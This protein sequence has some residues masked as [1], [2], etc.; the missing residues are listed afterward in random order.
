MTTALRS[1]ETM[2]LSASGDAVQVSA[3]MSVFLAEELLPLMAGL[4]PASANQLDSNAR[5]V[6]LAWGSMLRGFNAQQIREA[7]LQL[8][9]DADR[10]FAPRPA[11]VRAVIVKG[12][13]EPKSAA[14]SH[15]SIR[16][17]EMAAEVRV[18][19]RDRSVPAD[20][21]TRELQQVLAEK[22]RQGVT[23][24]GA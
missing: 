1:N 16:A 11:E 18:F 4:W 2:A 3:R 23:V 14:R 19:Q 6:A 10:Q 22:V 9:E 5:G 8:G 17:C 13:F 21:V 15:I 12:C 20:A 24:M 7:V